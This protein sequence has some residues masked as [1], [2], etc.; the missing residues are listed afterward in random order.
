MA[1]WSRFFG[2]AASSAAGFGIGAAVSPALRPITQEVANETWQRYPNRPL[3][4]A[5]AA[6]AVIRG[7]MDE[8][9]AANEA[10]MS[11]Y[12]GERFATFEGLAG[13]P[14]GAEQLLELWNRGALSE[15][16][17]N[18]GL[19]QSRLRP[20]WVGPVKALRNVLVP[21]S[22]LIR[23]AVREVFTP[24]LRDSLDLDADYPAALTA[25][26]AQ[27]GLSEEDARNFWAA[28]WDLPSA[29]QMAE[30][31]FRGELSE[32]QFED[33]LR[34][35]DYAPTWR[36][37]LSTILRPIPGLSDMV[38]FAVREAYDD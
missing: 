29:T 9:D 19:R 13:Q 25:K 24:A 28:H 17:V 8:G 26:A 6:E 21:V 5:D 2:N 7:L 14:P 33:G 10:S 37:K 35:L 31:M 27:L 20:E 36:K 15:D 1:I 22:D 38:R 30:M 11:G 23:M 4:P 16:R 18:D 3:S 32:A 12:N 34:A